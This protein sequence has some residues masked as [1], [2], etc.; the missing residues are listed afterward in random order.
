MN[1]TISTKYGLAPENIENRSLNP[2]DG[3]FFQEIYDFVRLRKTENNQK[4][5]D[6]YNQKI[7][8]RKKTLWSPLNLAEK[9]LL[10][11]ERLRKKDTPGTLHKSSTENMPYF[12]RNRIFTNYKRV[13]LE[14][15]TYLY[16]LE[17]DGEKVKG[18]F[19]RQE[20]FVLKN[21]FVR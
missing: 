6:K 5:N 13:K 2:K 11:A 14:N 1:E 12:Y 3:K 20:L 8:K 18:R 7:D 10:L 19:L 17:E 9:V 16:W 4:R 21:Q 15:G